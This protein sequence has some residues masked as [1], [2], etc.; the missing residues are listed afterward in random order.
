[1]GTPGNEAVKYELDDQGIVVKSYHR[2]HAEIFVEILFK[3]R[4][5]HP[6]P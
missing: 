1:V 2:E 4:R 3:G 5:E 6:P